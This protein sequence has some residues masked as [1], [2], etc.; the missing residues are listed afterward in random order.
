MNLLFVNYGDFTTN[1]L[2]HIGGFANTLAARG[3]ACVIAVPRDKGS[4]KALADPLFVPAAFAEI[5]QRP[6]FFPDGRGPDLI[7]AWTPR[8]NVRQFVLA[9]QAVEPARLIVHLEDDEQHLLEAYTGKPFAALR[10]LDEPARRRL[11]S[12]ALSHPW[13]T[14]NLLQLADGATVIID[15]LRKFVPSDVPAQLLFPGV[16]PIYFGAKPDPRLRTELGLRA[17][18]RIAV[19]TG[20]N[21]FA[22][23]PEIRE[24]Y[25]AV[26]LLNSRGIP[27]RLVRTGFNSP[28]FRDGI[29]DAVQAHVVD[30]GFIEK[31]RLPALLALADVLVQPGRPGPFNDCRLPSKLPEFL[32]SGRPVITPATNLG[33]LLRDGEDALLLQSGTPEEI[34]VACSRVFGDAELA[35]RLGRN[36]ADFARRHF[37][38][39]A[40]TDSLERLYRDCLQREPR[41]PWKKLGRSGV[42]DVAMLAALTRPDSSSASAGSAQLVEQIRLLEDDLAALR[43]KEKAWHETELTRQHVANLERFLA[44]AQRLLAATQRQSD[45]FGSEVQRLSRELVEARLQ[46]TDKIQRMQSS[47]SWRLTMPLR[48]VR[49]FFFDS[50]KN[51]RAVLNNASAPPPQVAPLD[52]FRSAIDAPKHWLNLH[53]R[54]F[55][56]CGW[57]LRCDHQPIQAIRARTAKDTFSGASGL[58]RIDVQTSQ[59]GFAQAGRSG[60]AV[61]CA[62]ADQQG[63]IALEAQTT[64]GNWTCFFRIDYSLTPDAADSIGDPYELWIKLH[65]RLTPVDLGELRAAAE[66]WSDAPL[67]SVLMPVFNTP[68]AWLTRAIE[69]VRA[70]AYPRWELCIADDASTAPH[71]R[72]LLERAA[73]EDPR[74]KVVFRET[75]GHIAAASNSALELATGEWIALLDHDDELAPHA[76]F[77]IASLLRERPALDLIYSDEDKID[78]DGRRHTPY[79]KPEFLPDLFTSQNYL[80]HLI[81]YRAAVVREIGGFRTGYEGSQDWDLALRFVAQITPE[82]IA[83]IPKILYHWRA[84]PGSTSL[85]LSEKD[86]PTEAARRALTDHF[87]RRHEKVEVL[88]VTGGHWRVKRSPPTPAPL[89]SIIIPTRNRVDLLRRCIESIQSRTT[90]RRYEVLIVDNQSDEPT[91]RGWLEQI[92]TPSADSPASAV[93]PP[94]VRVLRH[95]GPFNFSALNNHAVAHARGEFVALLNND[96][97]V[98]SPDWLDEMLAHAARPEIGCVGAMLYYPDD[99]IQHAGIV[100]GVGG[101]AAH[102]FKLQPRGSEGVFNRARLAQNYSAVTAA[103]LVVRKSIYEQVGGLDE[104][105]LPI[106]FNDV[107]FCLKVRA[108][109]FQNLWTPFAEFYHHESASRGYEDTPEKHARF[110]REIKVMHARWGRVLTA[111]PAYNPNLSLEAED[112]SIAIWPREPMTPNADDSL[113]DSPA[114]AHGDFQCELTRP[115]PDELCDP[116][117]IRAQGWLFAG[118]RH[119]ELAAIELRAGS[120][121]IGATRMFFAPPDAAA[122]HG[123]S[124]EA[125]VGFDILGRFENPERLARVGLELHAR[126][127]DGSTVPVITRSV[128]LITTDY[129]RNPYGEVL[130][131]ADATEVRHRPQIY[132]SG[133]SVAGGSLDCLALI[134]RYLGPPPLR[135]IDVGC[136]LGYYGQELRRLGY[137]WLGVEVKASD[138]AELARKGL[139]HHQV[140]GR[141]LPFAS[142]EFDAAICIEVL[143]HIENPDQFLREIRRVAPRLLVSVP[144]MELVPYFFATSAVPWHLL[145]ADRKNFFTRQSLRE[146]LCRHFDH[147]EVISYGEAALCTREGV[148]LDY[149]LFAIAAAEA[150]LK[151]PAPDRAN[152]SSHAEL[153]TA[154]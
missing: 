6:R 45:S 38:L 8:E 83:H 115:A 18:E 36:G 73:S 16:D 137:D 33:L 96:L 84:I 116:L 1:S 90:Y 117:A 60:F 108:A 67:F 40:N 95:D 136:G 149:H 15:S 81:A 7:H 123:L 57:V 51:G 93:A 106:A 2:N 72:P 5:L 47:L 114:E 71:V 62:L 140:D 44:D 27:T 46:L 110:R 31:R 24:L 88:P 105:E 151:P 102:A 141:S 23:E 37:D 10:A 30:L 82:R 75:N 69:S 119:G 130:L 4:Q 58:K 43:A 12:D 61:E 79:F 101:V 97:E 35:A 49:R 148:L 91:T 142:A 107:D 152:E 20:S 121:M 76:L 41:A 26:A 87:A 32:A 103:C 14:D 153:V 17:D 19:L 146:L 150:G 89:V 55:T 39:A 22:N 80:T 145:A 48:A 74:I 21:T 65:E 94:A 52:V 125:C 100:L 28:Q 118:E 109:G 78:A 132:G 122:L 112:F 3:H 9:I 131:A 85:L 126:F 128:A 59:P 50:K 54:R 42:S 111:D 29:P 11:L 86:Y 138:C 98:I 133:P 154:R 113:R 53:L 139:P 77:E 104:R 127:N 66:G 92:V 34:A 147:V 120:E 143:E 99:T 144:N 25:L 64:D 56:I 68:A 63:W 13:R 129:R 134:R 135:V 70:Q 124:R